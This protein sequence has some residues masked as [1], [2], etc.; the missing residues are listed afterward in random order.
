M[1]KTKDF[2]D[3][4]ERDSLTEFMDV[5]INNIVATFYRDKSECPVLIKIDSIFQSIVNLC[6]NY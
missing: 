3:E 6:K 4:W 1:T 5:A 2:P